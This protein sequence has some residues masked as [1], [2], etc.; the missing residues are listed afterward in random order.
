MGGTPITLDFSKAQPVNPSGS[1]VTLDFS[2]AQPIGPTIGPR[3]A[4]PISDAFNMTQQGRA[5]HPVIAKVT[6]LAKNAADYG[7]ILLTMS[8]LLGGPGGEALG[9]LGASP[10]V[11]S[12]AG[13]GR[14]AQIASGLEG[15]TGGM[16]APAV[17][18]YL[19]RG[20]AV[21]Q[22]AAQRLAGSIIDT[23]KAHPVISTYVG[24]HLA[25]ALGIPLPKV[26]KAIA[27]IP[28]NPA[29]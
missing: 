1:G 8:P 16:A 5:E 21:A 7:K 27:L 10:A 29:P 9:A 28:E 12:A 15:S 25:N 18:G 4:T 13:F 14:E 2:K 6:D 17:P 24:T 20:T 3:P 22:A 11:E 26:L 19:S 23:V